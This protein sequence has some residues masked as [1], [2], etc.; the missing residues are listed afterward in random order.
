MLTEGTHTI[1]M[2]KNR[3]KLFAAVQSFLDEASKS[4]RL[5]R[6]QRGVQRCAADPGRASPVPRSNT[7][8]ISLCEEIE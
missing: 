2:E 5:S 7:R 1:V 4:Q 6:A 3:L 8:W